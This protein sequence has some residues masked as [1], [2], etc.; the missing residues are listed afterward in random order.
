MRDKIVDNRQVVA[1]G[2]FT[3]TVPAARQHLAIALSFVEQ[4]LAEHQ[5]D[6]QLCAP[7]LIATEE[8]FTNIAEYAYPR[9][10]G[11]VSLALEITGELARLTFTD[12]GIPHD[13][14]FGPDPDIS[15]SATDREIGGL[16][17][18][19][20]KRLMD[21]VEY[22]REHGCNILTLSKAISVGAGS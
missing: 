2:V 15:L 9:T 5:I 8:V 7:F 4:T 22:S 6:A 14:L 16:G 3:V 21:N 12:A 18:F 13:P 1:D 10:A 19:L 17:V 11:E 20:V